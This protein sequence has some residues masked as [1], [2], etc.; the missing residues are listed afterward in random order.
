MIRGP[1]NEIHSNEYVERFIY[2]L[3]FHN[4]WLDSIIQKLQRNF[5]SRKSL[6]IVT[7]EKYKKEK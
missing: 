6:E 3:I 5:A 4:I 2:G 7:S 1:N